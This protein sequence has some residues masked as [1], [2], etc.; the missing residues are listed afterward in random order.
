MSNSESSW[1]KWARNGRLSAI[2]WVITF[3]TWVGFK[4]TEIPLEG[5]DVVFIM[6]SGVLAGNLGITVIKPNGPKQL[7]STSDKKADDVDA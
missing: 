7:P 1:V 2:A 5:L 3:G 4:V 6:M